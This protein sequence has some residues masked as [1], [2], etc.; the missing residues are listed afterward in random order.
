MAAMGSRSRSPAAVIC[1]AARL[2]PLTVAGLRRVGLRRIGELYPMPRDALARR[3]GEFVAHR[4]DQM[5]GAEPE[6]LSPLGETPV[7]RVRLSFAEPIA[8]PADFAHAV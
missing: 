5:S 3:F 7:R 1:G 2:D 4:L 6:P 8:D